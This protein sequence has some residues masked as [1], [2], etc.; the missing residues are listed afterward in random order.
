MKV[1]CCFV[2]VNIIGEESKY[3]FCKEDVLFFI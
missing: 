2:E 3:G 1:I